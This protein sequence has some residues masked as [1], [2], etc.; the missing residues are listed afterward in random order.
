MPYIEPKRQVYLDR[1]PYEAKTPG[2]LN[3]VITTALVEYLD[4]ERSYTA[5]NEIIG[6]LECAKQE[7]YRRVVVPYEDIKRSENGDVY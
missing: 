5:Y 4:G 7:F 3:Y 1:Y 6:V 2:E